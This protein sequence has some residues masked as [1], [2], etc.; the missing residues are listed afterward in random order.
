MN[1]NEAASLIHQAETISILPHLSADGDALGSAFSLKF[2]LDALGKQATV[3][4]E[5]EIQNR[6]L[7]VLKGAEHKIIRDAAECET[8]SCD[9][10]I[11]VDCADIAR[12]GKRVAILKDAPRSILVDHHQFNEGF[13]DVN[14]INV[15]WAATVIGIYQII[16][17]LQFPL[18]PAIASLLY[19]GLVTDTG[20]FRHSNTTPETHLMAAKLLECGVNPSQ[21]TQNVFDNITPGRFMLNGEIIKRAEFFFE[22]RVCIC[23]LP[24]HIFDQY[25]AID[26]DGE[27][28][29]DYLRNIEG[30][31]V[32][33]YVKD[34]DGNMK[35]SMRA[36]NFV[37]VACIA[38][39]FSGGGHKRAAG[40]SWEGS[41]EELKQ[42]LLSMF[43]PYF[44]GN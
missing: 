18:T 13:A 25:G 41:Y 9:L 5:E 35:I 38:A 39:E 16:Q 2:M 17:A 40:A 36:K 43:A 6:Y 42:K 11:A 10:V 12:L 3:Y 34:R 30:V 19:V 4:L 1:F 8:V 29:A 32:S 14:Y 26:E 7:F 31:E 33:V 37:D 28:I 24:D 20:G 21:V 23:Y 15:Q 22:R 27:G 44:Q